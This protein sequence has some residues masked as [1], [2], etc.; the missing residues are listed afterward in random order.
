M[1]NE[2]EPLWLAHFSDLHYSPGNL[3]EADRCFGFAVEN[4]IVSGCHVAVVSGDSTD[5]G[6]D[7]HTPALGS[8]ARR[9]HRLSGYCPVLMLQG[10]F[11]HEPPGTLDVIRLIGAQYPVYVADRIHQVALCDGAFYPSD[12]P[13]FTEAEIDVLLAQHGKP[14]VVFT[15]VPTVNKA[16]LAAAAGVA[17]AATAVGDHLAAYLAAAGTMNARLRSWGIATVGVSHGTVNGCQTE[18]GV[19][20]A[21]FDHEFGIGALFDA[22]CDG[23]LLGHIHRAQQ[24][25]REGRVI[26]YPGSI[27]RF[28]YGE[29]GA[30]G[31]LQWDIVPGRATAALVETPA[32]E[33]VC[34]DFDGP[35]DMNALAA[36]AAESVDKFVRVRWTVN[37]E[38]RQLVDRDAIVALFA[39]SAELKIEGHILPAVRSRAE[40]ISRA[41]SLP[42][43]LSRWGELTGVATGP[44]AERLALLESLDAQS[45]ADG[46]LE[47]LR[48]MP[49][50]EP[51]ESPA[52]SEDFPS[53]ASPFATP[54]DDVP[55]TRAEPL[56]LTP[57]AAPQME[58]L[59]DDLFA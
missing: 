21:G 56:G 48:G 51:A 33:T 6:L 43:K 27:G 17:K 4:A 32:R 16:V 38:H 34:V 31:Y 52:W 49:A 47:Q 42:E 36:L 15:C 13:I 57:A 44:L 37:E 19:P 41:A 11:S 55:T 3:A 22:E 23:F 9:I 39:K 30:K 14:E 2:S 45:I 35:P 53:G 59:T 12:G 54:G 46:V 58:W 5:H 29:I 8:L 40:G 10:T 18:H 50:P 1:L 20:M 24:W 25:E 26:A 28:H 7:A